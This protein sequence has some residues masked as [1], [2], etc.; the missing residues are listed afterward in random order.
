MVVCPFYSGLISWDFSFLPQG[1]TNNYL[2]V[3]GIPLG[4]P[5]NPLVVPP[6]PLLRIRLLRH[7]S[8][9]NKIPF[10]LFLLYTSI[11]RFKRIRIKLPYYLPLWHAS[12][13]PRHLWGKIP[14]QQ[15]IFPKEVIARNQIQTIFPPTTKLHPLNPL[16]HGPNSHVLTHYKLVVLQPLCACST[17]FYFCLLLFPRCFCCNR[18]ALFCSAMCL[19][20]ISS[21]ISCC[22]YHFLWFGFPSCNSCC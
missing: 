6:L 4:L 20:L 16:D 9:R 15:G 13:D 19:C 2:L 5:T 21:C 3:V 14:P 11:S 8:F 17:I 1:F 22:V 18:I 7:Y 10:C 12:D